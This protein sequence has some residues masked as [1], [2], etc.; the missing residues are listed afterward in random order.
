MKYNKKLSLAL[1]LACSSATTSAKTMAAQ[2]TLNQT[3]IE[4]K[5]LF[6]DSVWYS[7]V[8]GYY[9]QFSDNKLSDSLTVQIY[10]ETSRGLI[11]DQS[12][13][14]MQRLLYLKSQ[15]FKNEQENETYFKIGLDSLVPRVF[16]RVDFD[17]KSHLIDEHF[18]K[19]E[20]KVVY[21]Q[22][23]LDLY[24]KQLQTYDVYINHVIN[25]AGKQWSDFSIPDDTENPKEAFF[26]QIDSI[27]KIHDDCHSQFIDLKSDT[28]IHY[29]CDFSK[30][31]LSQYTEE[32]AEETLEHH[33][34]T[35]SLFEL[36]SNPKFDININQDDWA[37][38]T[39]REQPNMTQDKI[40]YMRLTESPLMLSQKELNSFLDQQML[41][42]KENTTGLV[43]DMRFNVGGSDEVM[44]A[45]AERFAD[46]DAD[47]F[48]YRIQASG[49]KYLNYATVKPYKNKRFE[50]EPYQV[51]E[52]PKEMHYNYPV[53]VLISNKTVSAADQF[54]VAMKKMAQDVTFVGSPT[55][56]S[57]SD[58]M[59][60]Q[61][62]NGMKYT[63]SS[64]DWIQDGQSLE[65]DENYDHRGI[66]PTGV[67]KA[68]IQRKGFT[69]KNYIP[70]EDIGDYYHENSPS[71]QRA[72]AIIQ[73]KTS[74]SS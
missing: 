37:Y 54:A 22:R 69:H 57:Y 23:L 2:P 67:S 18:F 29:G 16:K 41:F 40:G 9:V 27:L 31:T 68:D 19:S 24:K 34:K 11:P 13:G 42:F 58:P 73:A 55:P 20:N 38:G 26:T 6:S 70:N 7:E 33:F 62:P 28:T 14:S 74:P 51:I 17:I 63:L 56:S 15:F 32:E 45:L 1:I 59:F 39:F 48:T 61:L 4:N 30:A 8:Y 71:L 35:S 52:T 64:H 47:K 12:E 53:V 49:Q 25:N 65:R 10:Y 46:W 66:Y 43:I 3:T 72:I 50:R 5:A 21:Y 36:Q 60:R 44:I